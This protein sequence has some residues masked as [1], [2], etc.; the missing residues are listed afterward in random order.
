METV[1]GFLVVVVRDWGRG[2]NVLPL[3]PPRQPPGGIPTEPRDVTSSF[4]RDKHH[5]SATNRVPTSCDA[6]KLPATS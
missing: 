3:L 5:F 1:A 4:T 6:P 2:G